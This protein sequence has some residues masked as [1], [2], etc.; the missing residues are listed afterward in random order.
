MCRFWII[1]NVRLYWINRAEEELIRHT[2]PTWWARKGWS[3]MRSFFLITH[4]SNAIFR[5]FPFHNFLSEQIPWM[6]HFL[7]VCLFVY[8]FSISVR[9]FCVCVS[10][11]SCYDRFLQC[12]FCRYLCCVVLV[13]AP[14]SFLNCVLIIF[15]LGI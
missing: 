6:L 1:I 2:A 7:F 15:H 4:F 11:F 9:Q 14:M 12:V 3:S 10:F 8:F 13:I 5:R